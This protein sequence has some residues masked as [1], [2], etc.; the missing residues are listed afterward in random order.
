MRLQRLPN[1]LA[2]LIKL[3]NLISSKS[4]YGENNKKQHFPLETKIPRKRNKHTKTVGRMRLRRLP[5]ILKG[6]V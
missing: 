3:I 2:L 1:T 4:I 5:Y 6:Y